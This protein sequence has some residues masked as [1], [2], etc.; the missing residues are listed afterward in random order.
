MNQITAPKSKSTKKT[1]IPYAAF[2]STQ[3]AESEAQAAAKARG[4]AETRA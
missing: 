4:E 1:S 2:N 3:G